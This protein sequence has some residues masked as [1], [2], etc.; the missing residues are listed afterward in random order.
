MNQPEA[1]SEIATS[2]ARDLRAAAQAIEALTGYA[3]IHAQ[4][5]AREVAAQLRAQAVIH[6]GIAHS[7]KEGV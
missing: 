3:P 5:M 6:D 2:A 4:P 7:V 1:I